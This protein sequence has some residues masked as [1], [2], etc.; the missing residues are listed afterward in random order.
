MRFYLIFFELVLAKNILQEARDAWKDDA[1]KDTAYSETQLVNEEN[2]QVPGWFNILS[3]VN[4][5]IGII[6]WFIDFDDAMS[7]SDSR[8]YYALLEV[9]EKIFK[10]LVENMEN[11]IINSITGLGEKSIK[12][13]FGSEDLSNIKLKNLIYIL[14]L[15]LVFEMFNGK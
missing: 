5:N 1:S 10:T 4:K 8:E 11:W 14:V 3:N 6:S 12:D 7:R 9:P 15:R 2:T 13:F